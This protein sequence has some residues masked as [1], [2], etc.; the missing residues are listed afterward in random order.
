MKDYII[1]FLI[2]LAGCTSTREAVEIKQVSSM[3]KP[4]IIRISEDRAAIHSILYPLSCEIKKNINE[5]IFYFDNTFV[6]HNFNLSSGTGGCFLA[7]QDNNKRLSLSS[8]RFDGV[9]KYIIEE[10]DT[11][12]E[13]LHD[14]Y[15]EMRKDKKDTIHITAKDFKNQ[16]GD[17]VDKYFDGDSIVLHFK[18]GHN[19]YNVPLEI[20]Y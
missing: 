14:Y 9:I 17:I 7:A 19:L 13:L 8:K 4:V 10:N 16:F 1:L 12:N 6:F 11:I 18:K 20:S 15:E 5:E 2:F 3:E